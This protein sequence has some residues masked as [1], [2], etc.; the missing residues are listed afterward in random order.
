MDEGRTDP[1]LGKDFEETGKSEHHPD[2]PPFGFGQDFAQV[3]DE[4]QLDENLDPDVQ[5]L[6]LD[7]AREGAVLALAHLATLTA[8]VSRMTVTFTCPG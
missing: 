4:G 8:R 1:E 6:P 5:G 3:P 2:E 7:G